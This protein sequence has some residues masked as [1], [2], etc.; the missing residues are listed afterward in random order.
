MK[1]LQYQVRIVHLRR[2]FHPTIQ[3]LDRLRQQ[4]LYSN[5]YLSLMHTYQKMDIQSTRLYSELCGPNLRIVYHI[6]ILSMAYL[7]HIDIQ[8]SPK[9]YSNRCRYIKY[10]LTLP[11]VL[12]AYR[13]FHQGTYRNV[14][15]TV[16][17]LYILQQ[18]KLSKYQ[19]HHLLYQL[20]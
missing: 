12:S 16:L 14:Q 4:E 20:I 8:N 1:P 19:N 9:D 11:P 18:T 5:C 7:Q 15:R 3:S 6:S 17:F 10:V 2:I 13:I